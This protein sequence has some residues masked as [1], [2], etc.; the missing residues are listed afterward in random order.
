[1]TPSACIWLIASS[2]A[3]TVLLPCKHCEP[4]P[5][6]GQAFL[7]SPN[8]KITGGGHFCRLP[9]K[10]DGPGRPSSID[11]TI[12]LRR[13]AQVRTPAPAWSVNLRGLALGAF[14][15]QG[16]VAADVDLDL[17][18]L[19]FGFLGQLD[20]ENAL[21]VVGGDVLRV[22]GIRQ[23]EG[24]GEAAILPLHAPIVLFFLFFFELALA[25]N[26]EG[27]VLDADVDVLLVDS[28]HFNLQRDVLFVFVDVNG[29]SEGAGG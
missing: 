1:M 29:R 19:G 20:V 7:P 11:R 16:L 28:R 13:T 18:G 3:F 9:S 21:V 27:V 10:L 12:R 8:Q 22:H 15:F 23:S 26:G 17:L 14:A 25:V 24:T 2:V 6:P 4:T 5:P